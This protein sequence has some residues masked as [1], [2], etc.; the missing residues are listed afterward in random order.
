MVGFLGLLIGIFQSFLPDRWLPASLLL[1]RRSRTNSF[2]LLWVLGISLLHTLGGAVL[3]WG[4][5]EVLRTFGRAEDATFLHALALLLLGGGVIFRASRFPSLEQWF[6]K[7]ETPGAWREVLR[8]L[9][10][11]EVSVVLVLEA[12]RLQIDLGALLIPFIWGALGTQVGLILWSRDLWNRPRV[13][14][15]VREFLMRLRWDLG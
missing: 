11:S 1:W 2:D 5:I 4:L 12:H 13:T 7:T 10:P 6:S 15:K 3:G 9:G 8:S 14:P